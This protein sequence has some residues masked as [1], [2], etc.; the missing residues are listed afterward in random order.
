MYSFLYF[1][2]QYQTKISHIPSPSKNKQTKK[3]P[4]GKTTVCCTQIY[5][6]SPLTLTGTLSLNPQIL[7]QTYILS[8]LGKNWRNEGM[9]SNKHEKNQ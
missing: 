3:N 9:R 4:N 2:I 8:N 1:L 6:W 7:Q 5:L